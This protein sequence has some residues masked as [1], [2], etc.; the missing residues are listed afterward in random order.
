MGI[1]LSASKTEKASEDGENE[2]LCYG[3]SS[4]Q[5]WWASM[6][7]VVRNY[8]CKAISKFCAKY[9]HEMVL[10]SEAYLAG[11]LSG[12]DEKKYKALKQA[13]KMEI[14]QVLK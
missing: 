14:S 12:N 8:S 1:Y 7:D 5:G 9:L 4:M 3:L 10:K 2:K 11:E 13:T 6:E